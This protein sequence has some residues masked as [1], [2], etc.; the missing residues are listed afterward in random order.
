ML[1]VSQVD[2]TCV[3]LYQHHRPQGAIT[4]GIDYSPRPRSV[5][6]FE[7][8]HYCLTTQSAAPFSFPH[9]ISKPPLNSYVPIKAPGAQAKPGPGPA[10]ALVQPNQSSRPICA[11][12]P[13]R[14]TPRTTRLHPPGQASRTSRSS[15]TTFTHTVARQ[16]MKGFGKLTNKSD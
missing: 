5:S 16:T 11:N 2:R 8:L 4:Y 10:M 7:R 6:Q 3:L 12:L 9:F 14:V 15:D 1:P 13:K